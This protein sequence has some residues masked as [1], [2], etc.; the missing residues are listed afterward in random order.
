MGGEALK[1]KVEEN[2]KH[3]THHLAEKGFQGFLVTYD[4]GAL[5]ESPPKCKA[6][7]PNDL[8]FSSIKGDASEKWPDPCDTLGTEDGGLA[9]PY[10]DVEQ[11]ELEVGHSLLPQRQVPDYHIQGLIREEALVDRGHAGGPADVPD[12]ELHGLNLLERQ[13]RDKEVF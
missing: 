3:T 7:L 13:G 8:F 12:V 6:F 10:L 11:P 2:S 1:F 9:P 5:C 4:S